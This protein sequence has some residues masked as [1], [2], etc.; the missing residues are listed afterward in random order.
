MRASPLDLISLIMDSPERPLDFGLVLEL[1]VAAD[2]ASLELGQISAA[3]AFPQARAIVA[4]DAWVATPAPVPRVETA[5]GRDAIGSFLERSIDPTIEIPFRQLLIDDGRPV[6]VTHFH[7]AAADLLSA[8]MFVAHQLAVASGRALRRDVD[9]PMQP[10]ALRAH[11][12]P[13]R[14]SAFAHHGPSSRL[15]ARRSAPSRRRRFRT[16]AIERADLADRIRGRGF[17]YNDLLARSLLLAAKR[18]N[19]RFGA[20]R[21]RLALWLPVDIRAVPFHGFGNGSSRIRIYED[22]LGQDFVES[23]RSFR[24]QVEWSK[25]HGEW[26]VPDDVPIL[27]LPR[28]LRERAI[29][30]YLSRPWV[31]MG[32]IL[33]SHAERLS[34][35]GDP[36]D[37]VSD[38]EIVAELSHRYPIGVAGVTHRGITRLTFTWDPAMLD[39][40]D[41]ALLIALYEETLAWAR[42]LLA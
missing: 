37:G 10:V 38:V 17:T 9:A 23:C 3:R 27:R 26:A 25:T 41:V 36:L 4:N 28:P 6:L 7:H 5:L 1:D 13:V 20:R 40:A 18:F 14:R 11:P 29:R 35:D 12:S 8:V 24:A 39:E 34:E 15:H 2:R 21:D 31:D 16:I 22:R 19:E 32:T 30:A 33:F 42:K